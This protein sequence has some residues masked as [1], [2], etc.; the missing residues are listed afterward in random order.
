MVTDNTIAIQLELQGNFAKD[1]EK[2]AEKWEQTLGKG[3]QDIKAAVADMG[4]RFGGHFMEY[5]KADKEER[6]NLPPGKGIPEKGAQVMSKM[7]MGEK[8]IGGMA[9]DMKGM[10]A[11]QIPFGKALG[12]GGAIG[13]G[14]AAVGSILGI[15]K[16]AFG[17]SSI[18][19]T[20]AKSF[21]TI[22]GTMADII[23]M[24][25]LP[26]MFKFLQWMMTS[27]MP[28]VLKVSEGVGALLK[29]NPGPLYEML[30][31]LLID[32]VKE[33]VILIVKAIPHIIPFLAKMILGI[34]KGLG[35]GLL[36]IFGFHQGGIASYHSG[37]TVPGGP[38]SEQVALLQG[39]ETVIPRMDTVKKSVFGW[40][41]GTSKMIDK[42]KDRMS[43]WV[44]EDIRKEGGTGG[45]WQRW[46]DS[47]VGAS[48]LPETKKG[49]QGW[50]S[51]TEEESKSLKDKIWGWISD[52]A[53]T[54]FFS[55]IWGSIAGA[56]S[57]IWGG[58]YSEGHKKYEGEPGGK[59]TYKGIWGFLQWLKD[60]IP[61]WDWIKGKIG[62]G[63]GQ[64]GD[65]GDWIG[66]KLSGLWGGRRGPGVTE[67]GSTNTTDKNQYHGIWGKVLSFYDKIPTWD[68]IKDKVAEIGGGGFCC[69]WWWWW[70]WW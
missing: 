56:L 31:K 42:T 4:K 20:V 47:M 37:G 44:D 23:L 35:K 66:K 19:N 51:E 7:L 18:L 50:F 60:Q 14:M 13:G 58:K 34:L 55:D 53:V 46:Y 49:V 38:Q 2:S 32:V 28:W 10:A 70:W 43:R 15:V 40:F 8:G 29:G 52:N 64:I 26:Y 1:L 36:G 12:K 39:G 11:S 45:F 57:D 33:A 63:V 22:M 62:E 24:P 67:W 59:P 65:I 54:N 61:S 5:S 6:K 17:S 68:Q 3:A 21:W 16:K 30:Y 9:K 48:I 25:M 69:C 41:S 27:V